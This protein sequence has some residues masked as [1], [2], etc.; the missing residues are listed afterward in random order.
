M[1]NLSHAAMHPMHSSATMHA[2]GAPKTLMSLLCPLCDD[3]LPVEIAAIKPSQ[4][5]G[6]L[7]LLKEQVAAAA[8]AAAAAGATQTELAAAAA[9]GRAAMCPISCVLSLEAL[10]RLMWSDDEARDMVASAGV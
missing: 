6:A 8:A 9:A 5:R 10:A 7:L 4:V 3:D 2:S 1:Q